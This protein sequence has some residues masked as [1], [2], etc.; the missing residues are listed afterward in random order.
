MDFGTGLLLLVNWKD[1]RYDAIL[2]LI[3][4][5]IKIVYY[6]AVI[7]TIHIWKLADVIIDIVVRHYSFPESII[8]NSSSMFNSKFWFLLYNFFDINPRL[9]TGFYLQTNTQTKRQPSSIEAYLWDF[10]NQEK[11]NWAK[12]MLIAEFH[13]IMPR[14][15]VTVIHFSNW[16][17]DI[18]L[19]FFSMMMQILTQSLAQ[20]NN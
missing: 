10:V 16:I 15:Q 4:W 5:L 1:D 7:T 12:L 6:N 13:I 17:L 20:L 19:I 18:I 3:D 14:M 8:S 2:V 9:S 11:N